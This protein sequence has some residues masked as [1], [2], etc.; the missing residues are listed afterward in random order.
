MGPGHTQT[1]GGIN[2]RRLGRYYF[3]GGA[4]EGDR[5]TTGALLFVINYYYCR[6]RCIPA[7]SVA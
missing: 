5:G 3:T 7:I 6:H 1:R 2:T 4:V